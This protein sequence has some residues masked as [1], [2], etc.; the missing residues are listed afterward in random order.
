MQEKGSHQY[1]LLA[2]A[3]K[4][5]YILGRLPSKCFQICF[6]SFNFPSW[7]ISSVEQ[8]WPRF[9]PTSLKGYL[10]PFSVFITMLLITEVT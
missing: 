5:E 7:E 1:A 3:G 9:L 10:G 2:K 6:T 8:A 4:G